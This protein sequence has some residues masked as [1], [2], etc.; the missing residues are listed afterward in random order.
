ME[1]YILYIF[2]AVFGAIITLIIYKINSRTTIINYQIFHSYLG[3]RL[4]H[5]KFGTVKLIHNDI[6]LTSIYVTNIYVYNYS[7]K[8]LTNLEV[9]ISIDDNSSII[10]SIGN[11]ENCLDEL[12]FTNSFEELIKKNEEILDYRRDYRIPVL[13]RGDKVTITLF[14]SNKNAV[15]PFVTMVSNYTGCKFQFLN[16]PKQSLWGESLNTCTLIGIII[17][18]IYIFVI[19]KFTDIETTLFIISV[20]IAWLNAIIGFGV[21]KLYRLVSKLFV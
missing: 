16:K 8:D 18:V 17:L 6:E 10:Q 5:F 9:Q 12:N 1:Q 14:N 4:A 15:Q 11:H 21:L 20:L 13:N 19:I 2:T 7:G 3:S